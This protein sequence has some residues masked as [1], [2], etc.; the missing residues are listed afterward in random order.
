MW[1]IKLIHFQRA[2]F[3]REGN[4]NEYLKLHLKDKIQLELYPAVIKVNGGRAEAVVDTS[5][6]SGRKVFL[7]SDNH[8]YKKYCFYT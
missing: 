5:I 8:N 3:N 7:R 2:L 6:S 4:L 1:L